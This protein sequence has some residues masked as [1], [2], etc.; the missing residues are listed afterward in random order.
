MTENERKA[1]R[2]LYSLVDF[3]KYK[4]TKREL[5]KLFLN[6][7]YGIHCDKQPDEVKNE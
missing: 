3:E 5:A 7:L 6:N 4:K 1:I 2:E